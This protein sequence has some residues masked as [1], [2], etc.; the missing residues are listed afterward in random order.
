[1]RCFGIVPKRS[2][3]GAVLDGGFTHLFRVHPNASVL[4][5]SVAGD[6]LT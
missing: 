5:K 2:V 3:F 4:A 6:T 1:M